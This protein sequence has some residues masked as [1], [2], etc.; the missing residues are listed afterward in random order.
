[1]LFPVNR[2]NFTGFILL[3]LGFFTIPILIGFIIMPIGI[4]LF[5]F[6]TLLSIWSMI[7]GHQKFEPKIK[8]FK[9]QYIESSPILTMIFGKRQKPKPSFKE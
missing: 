6:G 3:I 7:P 8:T 9:D 2:Y 4:L 1:V 5:C